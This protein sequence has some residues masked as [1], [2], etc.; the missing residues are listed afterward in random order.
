MKAKKAKAEP[1]FKKCHMRTVDCCVSC[2]HV[3]T[4]CPVTCTNSKNN[5]KKSLDFGGRS[6]NYNEICD[7]FEPEEE[8]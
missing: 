4:D 1:W 2:K 6:V 3:N 8:E 5:T 7:Y